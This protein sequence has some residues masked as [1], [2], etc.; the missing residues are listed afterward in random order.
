MPNYLLGQ[1]PWVIV[2]VIGLVAIAVVAPLTLVALR[3]DTAH[4]RSNDNVYTAALRLSG[5]ALILIA[6]FSAV[7][8]W[9]AERDHS[10]RI[11]RE[12]EA[13]TS[14]VQQAGVGDPAFGERIGSLVAAYGAA[15]RD[16]ELAAEDI[17]A[18]IR[19]DTA[20]ADEALVAL[21]A[22]VRARAA[23]A[24]PGAADLTGTLTALATSR[25]DRLAW[26]PVLPLAILLPVSVIAL[27]TLALIALFPVGGD[28]SAKI[29]QVVASTA[30]VVAVLAMV[31]IIGSPS[32]NS[33][34]R[35]DAIAA[36]LQGLEQPR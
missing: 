36:Y 9:Q 27:A 20:P 19:R 11:M 24:A 26:R 4:D 30:V 1:S 8:V 5:G 12:F 6:S 14:L 28:R 32:L 22:A 17:D 13:A 29:A 10:T 15:V 33:S 7:S 3:R 16:H 21:Q 25:L 2:A 18:T 34:S 23:E 31:V 35:S